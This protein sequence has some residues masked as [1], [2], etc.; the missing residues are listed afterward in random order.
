ML[1]WVVVLK[2]IGDGLVAISVF[3]KFINDDLEIF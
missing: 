3:G 2:E 1:Y